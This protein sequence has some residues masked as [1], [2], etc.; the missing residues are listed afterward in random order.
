ME[1]RRFEIVVARD[2]EDLSQKAAEFFV[3]LA[4]K[5]KMV[6]DSFTVALSGGSTPR[7]LY[8]HIAL[9][10]IQRKIPWDQVHLFWGDERCVPP[11]HPASNY[12]MAYET[13]LSKVPI[14]PEN[15][16]PAVSSK[17]SP[18]Q[19]MADEYEE[20]LRKFFDP[21]PDGWPRFDLV[22]L[23]I[24]KDGHTASL[25]PDTPVL[26]ET[27][28]WVAA[29]Y[30]EKLK[31]YRLTLTIPVFNHA[32]HVLFLISGKEKAGIFRKII[33]SGQD[34]P[35]LPFQLIKPIRGDLLY[36]VDQAPSGKEVGG[37]A[38]VLYL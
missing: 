9:D 18:P 38:C 11:D 17:L 24:G 36:L 14:K 35:R 30:V 27:K 8:E 23:G 37:K 20:N 4:A 19:E 13:L 21:T 33:E 31:S 26:Q 25:F 1:G 2:L 5:V 28:R 34:S 7:G 32:K 6:K 16:H 12:H 29:L 3:R 22:L 15:V 10:S